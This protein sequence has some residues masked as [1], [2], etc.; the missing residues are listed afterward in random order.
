MYHISKKSITSRG[1]RQLLRQAKNSVIRLVQSSYPEHEWLPWK[2][3]HIGPATWNDE[4]NVHRFFLWA[5]G[6]SQLKL[7]SLD[8]WYQ[9]RTSEIKKLGGAS[10]LQK[11]FN[12]SLIKALTSVFPSHAW[13]E[14][15]FRSTPMKWWKD[16][17]NQRK[18]M[19]WLGETVVK[20]K[21]MEDWYR[22]RKAHLVENDGARLIGG[23]Y[24]N[25]CFLLLRSCFPNHEWLEWKLHRCPK[26]FWTDSKN[27]RRFLEHFLR[28]KNINLSTSTIDSI[29]AQVNPTEVVHAGG[30]LLISLVHSLGE[31]DNLS[32]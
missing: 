18:Y 30:S 10:L 15:K 12:G 1:G 19:Q 2:F 13:L 6:E 5:Q 28:T 8:G 23:Y 17:K 14:W 24:K 32:V 26:G 20:V 11:K 31:M 27:R 16:I 7:E 21:S 29:V 25:S 9:V 22:L 3:S 4:Q